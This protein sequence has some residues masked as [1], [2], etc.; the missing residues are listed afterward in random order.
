MN[1]NSFIYRFIDVINSFSV[2]GWLIFY[3]Y[4]LG[5]LLIRYEMC[6]I[7]CGWFDNLGD[8]WLMDLLLVELNVFGFVIL[9]WLF[10]LVLIKILF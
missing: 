9:F 3:V 8:F 1:D 6:D 2:W 7:G 4:L 10:W 5:L